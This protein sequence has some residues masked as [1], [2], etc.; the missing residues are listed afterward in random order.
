MSMVSEIQPLNNLK[1]ILRCNILFIILLIFSLL[2]IFLFTVII[3]YESKYDGA[4][5][6]ITGKIK[7]YSINGSKL[8]M[9]IAAKED[10]I[11]TYYIKSKEEKE[12]LLKRVGIGKTISLSGTLELP[13]NNTIPN[14]FN[15]RKYLYNQK[16]FYLFSANSYKIQDDN[17][18]IDKIKDYLYKRAYNL[19][20]GNYLL[21][22]VLGDKSLISSDIY[23]NYQTNGT[24][25]LLA[26]SGSHIAVLLT[27]FSFLL[28][29][30]KETPKLIILSAILLF[31][32]FITNFQA[33]VM[34]AIIFFILNSINKIRKLNYSNLQILFITAFILILFNPFIIYDLG[35]I[36]SFIICGGII[37]YSDKITGNYFVKMFKLSF[38]S[39]LFSLPISACINYEVNIT[40]I[41]INMIFVPWIS[42]I[43]F[44]L[45]IITFIF[46]FLNSL[47]SIT[48]TI[49]DFL[50]NLFVKFSLFINIPKTS[51]IL[52]IILFVFIILLKNNKKYLL[53]IIATLF[54]IKF[55]PKLDGHYY[56]YYL[57][58][59]QGDST[60]LVSPYQKEVI[61][62]DTGG[63]ITYETDDWQKSNKTYNLSDNTIKFLKSLGISQIDKLILTHGDMDHVGEAINIIDNIKVN[64]VIFNKGSLN[65]LELNITNTLKKQNINYYQ[66][67][68]ELDFYNNK[69]YSLN[70]ELYDN[71]NDNSIVLY[72]SINGLKLLF[73]GDAGVDAE[74]SLI[75]IYN[76]SNIDILKVGHHGSNTST[77][78]EFINYINPKYSIISVGRNNRY[79]H[80]K[81]EVLDI[82]KYTNIYRTD[83]D[84]SVV[85]KIKNNKFSI[86]TYVP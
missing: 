70:H 53:G 40:S 45:S 74:A 14:N 54:I 81:D 12:T 50:N 86:E 25:H 63:K 33:A 67:I 66:N 16:I 83:K 21:V 46:P 19:E 1:L 2:Y 85:F 28:R 76:I 10:I 31:F 4:E 51:I 37:Y 55:I 18:L 62:I 13:L 15:Y 65:D 64:T 11:T 80:P 7:E 75:D 84:G 61:M 60:T 30:F 82:L 52:I 23:N 47:F 5:T 17:N 8:Q 26:I 59:G 71:E 36:Y 20:N 43:V 9:T 35:F 27:V 48:L 69:L 56:I 44:P 3:K 24:S 32:A 42:V 49:T 72:T 22:L 6:T 41:L 73:M 58:I 29:R 34:R 39:F 68:K 57:D 78:L 38:I 77:S 79:N